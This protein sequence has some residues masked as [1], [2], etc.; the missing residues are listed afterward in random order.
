MQKLHWSIW[1]NATKA[2]VW[3][4]MLGNTTYRVWTKAFN[5]GSYFQGAW[6]QG[7]EIRFLGPNPNGSGEGGM[8]SRIHENRMHE[9]LSIEHLGII[10]NGVVDTTSDEVKKW[11]PAFENYTFDEKD[12]GTELKIDL[13]VADEYKDMFNDMWPKA[14][15]LLKQ[16]AEKAA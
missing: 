6:E 9:F 13:D 3:D 1:I 2:H 11:T 4:V 7:S 5:E 14:L 16:L 10:Q 12:G 15:Q 8:F